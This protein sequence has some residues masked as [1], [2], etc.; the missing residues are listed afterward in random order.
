MTRRFLRRTIGILLMC[1]VY[2]PL[3]LLAQEIPVWKYVDPFIGTTESG[4]VTRWGNDGGVYPGAVAVSGFMQL[5]PE[6]RLPSSGGYH[7]QDHFIYFF[8]CTNHQSGFPS[9]SSGRLYVMPLIS[10]T[11]PGADTNQ[12]G[13]DTAPPGQNGRPFSHAEEK[14]EPGYYRV[15]LGDDGTVVEAVATARAGEFRIYF[16]A[17]VP[18]RIFIG[19]VGANTAFNFSE[20]YTSLR[21]VPGGQV[22]SFPGT[23]AARTILLKISASTVSVQSAQKN[24]DVE[25]RLPF[26]ILR[27]GVREQWSKALSVVKVTDNN[28]RNKTIFYTALYHSLLVPWII[29]D[30]EGNYRGADGR[31][32]RV[33]G[34]NEYGKFSPWDS[35]RSLHPLLSLLF[36]DKESAMVRSMLDIYTQSG[37]LPVESMTGNHS[38][39]IIVD[40][41][42]K[43]VPGIDKDLAYKAMSRSIIKGPF[44]QGDMAVY[45]ERGYIPFEYPESVTRTLEYAYDDWTLGQFAG[46]VMGDKPAHAL[47]EE[48]SLAYRYLFYP[49]ALLMLPREGDIFKLR[50]GNAGY[51]EGDAWVYSYFVPQDPAGLIDIMGGAP[52][53]AAN[54]DSALTDGR[55]LFDNET[56]LQLPYLFNEAGLSPLTQKWVRTIMSNRYQASPDGLP[57]N[58]DLGAMSSWYV[59][60]ALGLF[61]A[62]PGEPQYEIGSPIF[63]SASLRVGPGKR[64]VIRSEHAGPKNIYIQSLSINGLPYRG[65]S[66]PHNM[67]MKGGQINV[68]MGPFPGPALLPEERK[69]PS[70]SLSD[71]LA[72]SKKIEPGEL[73]NVAFS[74]RN[75]GSEG[76]VQ[77]QLWV[78][79]RVVGR[80]N[81]LVATGEGIS[82]SISCRLYRIGKALLRLDLVGSTSGKADTLIVEVV[83]PDRP[84]P[85]EPEVL[86]VEMQPL[87]REG[88]S[89]IAHFSV[90]N[91]GWETKAF[92]L[93]LKVD[94]ETVCLDTILLEPGEQR[95][96][97]SVLQI[98]SKG[99]HRL[100][101]GGRERTFKL[102]GTPLEA[103]V[104]DL[105]FDQKK[106]REWMTDRSGFGN[107]VVLMG[108][109]LGKEDIDTLDTGLFL[110]RDRYLQIGGSPSLDE[111][112]EKLTMMLWVYPHGTESR[113]LV[114]IFTKGDNHVLQVSDHKT[115]TFF[116]GGWGRGDCTVDLP[117]DWTGHWHHIAGV[118]GPDGLRV[119]IDG[120]LRGYTRMEKGVNLSIDHNTWIVGRNEEFPGKRIYEGYVN[121]VKVYQETLEAADILSIYRTEGRNVATSSPF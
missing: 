114:D 60:S 34:H 54:L 115:L 18:P 57:G 113:G 27:A 102:Y 117:A 98:K 62:C 92:L 55:I 81:C 106:E 90:V 5:S 44:I 77:V 109:S 96:L 16:P 108:T 87:I 76:T 83:K 13:A 10:A 86:A 42:L 35:F 112:G 4:V 75:T 99:I 70:F 17:G 58:D 20:K 72:P 71:I 84:M 22:F 25:C 9:G 93:P 1:R 88:D 31:I 69:H 65:V 37:Y 8:S 23:V 64:W 59:F 121:K 50:P 15:R 89:V 43:G 53:F 118:C 80:K 38:I 97:S 26:D 91:T 29:S 12:P 79:G 119:Y 24:I 67:L 56:V 3:P 110:G 40:S 66:V 78:N 103:C 111:M 105:S 11:R 63:R 49:P 85:D 32:H 45:R 41:Y 2:T 21:T 82:D 47:L 48:A 39:P 120:Q 51:K 100:Q 107:H 36:P 95:A 19:D 74:L 7:Y 61:P 30:V 33:T 14:A 94:G 104:L 68:D 52:V 28:T 73:F 101:I 116:A 46:K 6:T